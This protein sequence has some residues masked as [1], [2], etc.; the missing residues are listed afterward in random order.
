MSTRE[1]AYLLSIVGAGD[2]NG[3]GVEDVIL[4]AGSRPLRGTA[5][6][7]FSL[8][9]VMTREAPGKPL[10]ILTRFEKA[11]SRAGF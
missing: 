9:F 6:S 3:D 11:A 10:E 4:I 8:G 7:A 1:D 5:T 2:Y